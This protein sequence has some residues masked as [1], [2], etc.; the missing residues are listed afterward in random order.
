MRVQDE[1]LGFRENVRT[2]FGECRGVIIRITTSNSPLTASKELDVQDC[3]GACFCLEG[4]KNQW[5]IKW[6]W[7]GRIY[8]EMSPKSLD[9]R[10]ILLVV[11]GTTTA[12]PLNPESLNPE[13]L[14]TFT[15]PCPTKSILLGGS[16]YPNGSFWVWGLG[17]LA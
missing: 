3:A 8:T 1:A 4:W 6:T 7:W 10:G 17:S 14:Q 11:M 15:S 2:I 13:F 9:R 12:K 16:I 5:N